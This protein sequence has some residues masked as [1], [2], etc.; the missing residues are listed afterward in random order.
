MR[1]DKN[2]IKI[3][4][5]LLVS[6]MSAAMLFSCGGKEENKPQDGT[7]TGSSNSE[8]ELTESQKLAEELYGARKSDYSGRKFRVYALEPG[9]HGYNQ[10]GESANEVWFEDAGSD[11]FQKSIFERNRST[12]ELLGIEITPVWGK[13]SEE[14]ADKINM[15]K[16]AGTDDYDAALLSLMEGMNCAQN[17]AVLNLMDYS[18]F[19]ESHPWWNQTFV[20]QC[21]LFDNQ[22]YTIAG[23]INIWDDCS[24]RMMVF[25]QDI[26]DRYNCESPYQQVFDGT[27]TIENMMAS[28]M[29][30]TQDLNGDGEYDENDCW[31]VGSGG[32]TLYDNITGLDTAVSKIG[33]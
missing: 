30:C 18:S 15:D 23:A 5:L 25:N 33:R 19:D 32:M 6:T 2:I 3:V 22:I 9:S 28:A 21:T 17:D 20:K 11:V 1:K 14:I 13:T 4:S 24:N 8:T 7:Q 12:Q 16:D 31:G 27:W 10:I 29:A 26:L